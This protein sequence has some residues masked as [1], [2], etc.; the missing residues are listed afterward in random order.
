M[1]AMPMAAELGRRGLWRANL[2]KSKYPN[3]LRLDE[4]G[5]T[6]LSDSLDEMKI[7]AKDRGFTFPYVFDGDTQKTAHAYGCLATP[8][9]FTKASPPRDGLRRCSRPGLVG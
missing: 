6:D 8:H 1:N 2:W 4:L 7:R 9:I 3:G 5:Y